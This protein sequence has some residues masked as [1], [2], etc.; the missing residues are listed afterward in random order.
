MT[1]SL[2]P[3]V[4]LAGRVL[5]E[6]ELAVRQFSRYNKY[7]V[8]ADL[9]AHAMQV[10]KTAQRA[11]RN[12]ARQAQLVTQLVWDID[13]LR[14]VL[15][16]GS[17]LKVFASFAQFEMLARLLSDLGKQAGGWHR[18]HHPKGQNAGAV[19]APPQRAQTLS[20]P[21]ASQAEAQA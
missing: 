1:Y 13:D 9:R 15:Q 18:Q 10:C 14:T 19:S 17:A 7:T 8:G 16:L 21:A 4:K 12:R 3:I 5:K 6:I 2:P 11:W 20:A